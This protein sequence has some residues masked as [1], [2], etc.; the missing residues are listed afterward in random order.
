MGKEA[1][2][3]NT[4]Q[5]VQALG[6]PLAAS[7][8][9]R[10]WDVIFQKEGTQWILRVY[11]DREEGVSIED[12]VEMTRL[13]NPALDEADP[14]PQEYILEVSSPGI[15]RKLTKP[16]HFEECMD[17]PVRVRL[18]RPLEDGRRE[19]E[20]VLI[21]LGPQGSFTLQIDASQSVTFEK[22][23]CASVVLLDEGLLTDDFSTDFSDEDGEEGT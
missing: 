10:I 9:L 7:I 6:D 22:K 16:S 2:K 18:I 17:C 23:E 19:L 1:Q 12:C 3:G 15:N 4:A 14:I 21:G 8:G 5:R 11:I 20:G 13:L